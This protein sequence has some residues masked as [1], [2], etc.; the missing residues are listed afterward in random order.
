M[1]GSESRTNRWSRLG[2]NQR[3]SA[4]EARGR[5]FSQLNR[6]CVNTLN[7]GFIPQTGGRLTA[8]VSCL[9]HIDVRETPLLARTLDDVITDEALRIGDAD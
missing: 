2:S 4:C 3:P 1:T 8:N 5:T 6:E 9:C 7:C